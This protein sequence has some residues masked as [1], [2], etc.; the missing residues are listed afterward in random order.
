MKRFESDTS[1]PRRSF[2]SRTPTALALLG[3][4]HPKVFA[5]AYPAKPLRIIV[6]VAPG[7]PTDHLARLIGQKLAQ[8]WGQPV[9]ID[10]RPGAGQL[11]GTAAAAKA[12]ADGYTLLMTTNVFP[13]NTFLYAKLPYDPQKDFVPVSLVASASLTLVVNPELKVSTLSELIAYAKQNPGKLNFGSS[14]VSSSLRFAV[15]LLKSMAGIEMTHVP[16]S[17]AAPMMT[18][19]LGNVVQ[20]AIVD[21]K[22]AK[23]PI[24]A[25]RVRALAVTS[26]ARSPN[27]PNVPT[28]SEEGLRG[29]AA[30]SW[31]G[32]LAPAGTPAPVVEKIQAEVARIL[33][34]PDVAQNL[35]DHDEVPIGSTPAEFAAYINA[36]SEK[37]GKIIKDNNITAQ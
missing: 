29:Y 8:A 25:G 6:A 31:F 37:W 26:A 19:L 24:D 21:S 17:G 5:Q 3:L 20:L 14:G 16:F 12:P 34:M 11:I 15:E 9:T 22:V 23:V 35:A 32:L 33:K 28:I 30:G 27:M 10:N 4:G 36:E 7:G 13:V 1:A 2:L 18:A